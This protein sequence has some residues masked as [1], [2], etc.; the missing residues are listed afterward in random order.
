MDTDLNLILSEEPKIECHPKEEI[1]NYHKKINQEKQNGRKLNQNKER[2]VS[3]FKI[4][5][6]LSDEELFCE[7]NKEKLKEYLHKFNM[8][9][10]ENCSSQ[11]C[12]NLFIVYT[13]KKVGSTSL[14]GSINL[15]LSSI[16]K[17]THIHSSYELERLG[18]YDI[19]MQQM[20]KIFKL[21]NK[22]VFII[23]IY[24][25]IFDICVS[26]FFNEINTHFQRDFEKYPDLENK[27]TVIK[28]F[29]KLF[30]EY[31]DTHN[32]DYYKEIYNIPDVP[33]TFDFKNKHLIYKDNNLTYIKLRLCDSD[34]WENILSNY[35]GYKFKN[36]VFNESEKK[37]WGPLYQYFKENYTITPEIYE[38]LKNNS[39]FKY[40]YTPEEQDKYLKKFTHKINDNVIIQYNRDEIKFYNLLL[41]ENEIHEI[42]SEISSKTN[43]PLV[44]NCFCKKCIYNNKELILKNE[45]KDFVLND[46]SSNNIIK[47]I[48]DCN[49]N[50]RVKTFLSINGEELLFI[51]N[52]TERD[53]GKFYFSVDSNINSN[54]IDNFYIYS[55]DKIDKIDNKSIVIPGLSEIISNLFIYSNNTSLTS[56]IHIHFPFLNPFKKE[57][58]DNGLSIS[59]YIDMQSELLSIELIEN[60]LF[61]II[62]NPNY[63]S[64]VEYKD[65]ILNETNDI[66]NISDFL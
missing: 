43:S 52:I 31:Y 17:T 36:I 59:E 42:L 27:D 10:D 49:S 15:Y 13:N 28:R 19:T 57:N 5:E 23:D 3:N 45:N 8:C 25:P 38:T 48:I 22:N 37:S 33:N 26:N 40:Y 2:N 58:V 18:I 6:S 64:K 54:F 21:F 44:Y 12:K 11:R 55:K 56:N 30:N 53:L 50:I 66:D 29:F 62:L 39:H 34:N 20:L 24:R 14:W 63:K 60:K 65:C 9:A 32:V 46:S 1:N 16:F 51:D 47:M 41:R 4:F 35:I 7:E 61:K